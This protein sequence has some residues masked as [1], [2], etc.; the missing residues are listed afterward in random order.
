LLST[1][2]SMSFLSFIAR[3]YYFSFFN[4]SFWRSFCFYASIFFTLASNFSFILASSNILFLRSASIF[5]LIDFRIGFFLFG[6]IFF[7][8]SSFGFLPR[9]FAGELPPLFFAFKPFS[10]LYDLDFFPFLFYGFI[11]CLHVLFLL[12]G[13]FGQFELPFCNFA[14][15]PRLAWFSS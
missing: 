8:G 7:G 10:V 13:F 6:M 1:T 4:F 15:L 3:R 5:S 9:F 2:I 12:F 11:F 14:E